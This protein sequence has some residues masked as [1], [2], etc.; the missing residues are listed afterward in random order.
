[1]FDKLEKSL[2]EKVV[3][4]KVVSKNEI[5][6]K[7]E[8]GK[9]TYR[10]CLQSEDIHIDGMIRYKKVDEETYSIT[11][12]LSIVNYTMYSNNKTSW[13]FDEKMARKN[14]K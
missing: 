8:N 1:M 14:K 11:K 2:E 12:V 9:S 4:W 5:Y 7:S 13:F 10:I 3:S 6:R